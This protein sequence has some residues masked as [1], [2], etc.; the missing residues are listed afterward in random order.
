M[1]KTE[2]A[3]PKYNSWRPAPLS[4][5]PGS[6][7]VHLLLL[8]GLPC[9]AHLSLEPTLVVLEFWLPLPW[10]VLALLMLIILLILTSH[11]LSLM[12]RRMD[13]GI[14]YKIVLLLTPL[15]NI[16]FHV[17][18]LLWMSHSLAMKPSILEWQLAMS[19]ELAT[20]DLIGTWDL[21]P[22]PLHAMPITSKWGSRLRKC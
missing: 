1:K 14:I 19:E 16:V 11:V 12:S 3:P 9:F 8:L 20:L 4:I 17:L 6:A 5:N 13:S 10:P 22:L 18:I 15:R 2:P 7:T 21:V